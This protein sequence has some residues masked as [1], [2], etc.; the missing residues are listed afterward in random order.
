MRK[1]VNIL[2]RLLDNATVIR[3]CWFDTFTWLSYS[4]SLYK[5][6]VHKQV[7]C[8]PALNCSCR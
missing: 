5:F 6:I 7:T 2:S 4:Y 8:L 1:V 3:G